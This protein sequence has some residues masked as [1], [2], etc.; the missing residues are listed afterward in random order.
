MTRLFRIITVLATGFWVAVFSM[1]VNAQATS[2]QTYTWKKPAKTVTFNAITNNPSIGDERNFLKVKPYQS[3]T[4][5]DSLAVSDGQE[6]VLMAYYD[7]DAA[8]NYNL[9]A[10][11]TRIQ[12]SIPSISAKSLTV[13]ASVSSDN[14][15]PT[16]VTDS[17]SLNADAPFSLKYEVGSAQLWNNYM[18]G[19][20]LSDAVV[21]EG[22]KLGTDKLDGL[23][24][25]GPK[26]SGYVTLKAKVQ[27]AKTSASTG[28]V[29]VV[30]GVPNT[31][32]GDVAALFGGATALG[33]LGHRLNAARRRR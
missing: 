5:T 30:N 10:K 11:N 7:N 19:A 18:R 24:P 17:T 20:K 31:G 16:L 13:N 23:V 2:H 29:G 9:K 15:A 21:G 12:I 33:A 32:P 6:V 27:F 4:Y 3:A 22:A 8:S 14:S 28:S 25:G 1:G 26:Y